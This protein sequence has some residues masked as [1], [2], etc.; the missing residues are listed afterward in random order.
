MQHFHFKHKLLG[1]HI[2]FFRVKD[3]NSS[4]STN[5]GIGFRER[6]TAFDFK[7]C[8]NEYVRYGNIGLSLLYDFINQLICNLYYLIVDRMALADMKVDM[9]IYL[10]NC[11]LLATR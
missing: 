4:R 3:P 1:T 10:F 2:L 9:I 11:C 8:L 7:S 6:E 5:L